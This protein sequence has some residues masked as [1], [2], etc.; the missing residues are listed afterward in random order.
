[1]ARL[2]C[3]SHLTALEASPEELIDLAA[4]FGFGGVGI[5]NR[6]PQHTA[7][8]WPISGDLKR[9][10]QIAERARSCGITVFEGETFSIWPDFSVEAM[11]AGLESAAAMGVR[12]IVSAGIDDEED[13]LVDSYR[14]LAEAAQPF[15]IVVGIEFMP[16][17]KL[18]TLEQ[19]RRV[20]A[21]IGMDNA[22]ILI[23]ALH[24]SRSGGSVEEV[25]R[26]Q[27]GTV[28]YV[29]LCD[30]P[31]KLPPASEIAAEARATRLYPGEGELDLAGLLGVLDPDLP[32]SL[33]A[34]H[35][36]H[37]HLPPRELVK[38]AAAATLP[39]VA[40]VDRPAVASTRQKN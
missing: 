8:R 36:D 30:A 23:D 14:Q 25:A 29:H 7:H 32:V 10:Q 3:I 19:A 6:P 34:P 31:A 22:R 40:A 1:M 5:R 21:R 33:E 2:V 39:F 20:Q 15:G 16:F 28:A 35:R 9:S 12:A 13:R 11:M 4:E 38:R 27:P 17:Q 24:L 37:G 18:R 26:L